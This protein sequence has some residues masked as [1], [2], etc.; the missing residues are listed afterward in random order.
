M[1][2]FRHG[3]TQVNKSWERL[4]MRVYS[5]QYQFHG[6]LQSNNALDHFDLQRQ[7]VK[8]LGLPVVLRKFLKRTRENKYQTQ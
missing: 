2:W 6:F 4:R 3:G 7:L 8:G 1:Q 5:R